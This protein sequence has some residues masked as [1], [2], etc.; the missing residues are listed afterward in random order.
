MSA[1]DR[2]RR[3]FLQCL[4]LAGAVIAG[5]GTA[6][7]TAQAATAEH[8]EFGPA[9]A[10]SFERLIQTARDN[11]AKPYREAPRP[12]AEL[13]AKIDYD[14]HGQIRYRPELALDAN[15]P[16]AYPV[17]FFHLGKW[18][19]QPMHAYAVD[20][21]KAREI[22]YRRDYFSMPKDNP[23]QHMP[24]DAG[25][26]GFRLHESRLRD[27]WRTQDWVAFLGA[28]YFRTIGAQGQYG[29][30]ARG[31]ALD[32]AVAG[33][34]EFPMF[35]EFYLEPAASTDAPMRI[36]ALLDGPGITGAYRFD[37]YRKT[38][39]IIEVDCR[40]FLRRDIMRL[41][42][43]PLTS[44][45]WFGEHGRGRDLDW[46]PEI[47]DSDGL[48]VWNGAGE[49]IWRPLRNPPYPTAV[50][51][52]DFNPRGFGFM[53]RDR[54]FDNYLDG[55]LYDRRPS[56]W[57]EPLGDWGEGSVQLVELPTDDEV[58]D[59]MVAM[60]VP[61]GAAKKGAE[62]S[63][64]YRMHWLADEPYPTPNLAQVVSTR[65]GRGGEPGT[66]RKPG[67]VR[68]VVEFAGGELP[69]LAKTAKIDAVVTSS[70]GQD[71][72]ILA[73]AEPV[74]TTDRWRVQ[75][76]LAVNPGEAVDLRL[77]LR[78]GEHALS[79]TWLFQHLTAAH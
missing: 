34:E 42:I 23:A 4:V 15:G 66:I 31:I 74:P 5:L 56:L 35:R 2:S 16:G 9:R 69:G 46:R 12:G 52:S 13:V 65:S 77:F 60:W 33:P 22:R 39:V 25:F 78:Q 6:T 79:E 28:S 1:V 43:A 21:G 10:F 48:A 53:Q 32:T 67:I 73:R 44:M 76:D 26:A 47:H 27:D 18:F 59:N 36:Y 64:R 40:L 54:N 45:F 55:V 37:L 3:R 57:I 71:K 41:G 30:S 38:G 51:F 62:Y 61:A 19:Q 14:E 49:R 20:Q 75:F 70:S 17:T 11:A 68:Y 63:F 7:G 8:L 58:H 72:V 24:D 50:S 29:L